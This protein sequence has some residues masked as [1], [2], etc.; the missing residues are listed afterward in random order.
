MNKK[1]V[2]CTEP[3]PASSLILSNSNPYARPSLG[4]PG[5]EFTWAFA[6]RV[7]F[8]LSRGQARWVSAF[9]P[10]VAPSADDWDTRVPV[11]TSCPLPAPGLFPEAPSWA[12]RP[13]A[14]RLPLARCH[15]IPVSVGHKV[16]G[17]LPLPCI[18]RLVSAFLLGSWGS[19]KGARLAPLV[20]VAGTWRKPKYSLLLARKLNE[21]KL[22]SLSPAPGTL[23][24]NVVDA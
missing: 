22:G 12:C 21:D 7:V 4:F 17:P 20:Q 18:I 24:D 2:L 16:W 13:P 14:R 5:I 9:F 8:W 1:T 23:P 11:L 3:S 15:I 19:S 10:L 6:S